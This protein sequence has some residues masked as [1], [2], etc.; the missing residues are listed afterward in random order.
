[1]DYYNVNYH[2]LTDGFYE[3]YKSVYS[4]LFRVI[5]KLLTSNECEEVTSSLLLR[6]CDSNFYIFISQLN[7][8]FLFQTLNSNQ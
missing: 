1:M 7:N 4:G 8:Q 5:S 6:D 3:N 2:A